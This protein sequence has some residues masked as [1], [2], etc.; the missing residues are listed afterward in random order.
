VRPERN[1]TQPT[2]PQ[3]SFR[4][5]H[6]RGASGTERSRRAIQPATRPPSGAQ[7][8]SATYAL[9]RDDLIELDLGPT[10]TLHI[11]P[12]HRVF[13]DH[14]GTWT[15]AADFPR[16]ETRPLPGLHRVRTLEVDHEHVYLALDG[17]LVLH[18]TGSSGPDGCVDYDS[19]YGFTAGLQTEH[20]DLANFREY[21][22]ALPRDN[23]VARLGPPGVADGRVRF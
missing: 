17:Q 1:A 16:A 5:N 15:P 19:D 14:Q 8:N 21:E 20:L 4:S 23:V 13:D 2:H 22:A 9:L 12:E 10:G 3:P 6:P 11:S 18:N 7:R